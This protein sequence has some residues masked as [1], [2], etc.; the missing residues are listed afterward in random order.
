[1]P[2][3]YINPYKSSYLA[4]VQELQQ[5]RAELT[6]VA[7]RISQ[8]EETIAALEPLASG[9]GAAPTAG[10]SELCRQILMSQPGAAFTAETMMQHLAATGVDMSGY[11]NPLAV[12]HTT[13]TR[14]VKPGTG[15][16]K[17]GQPGTQPFYLYDENGVSAWHRRR[18]RLAFGQQ[19]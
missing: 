15:F 19:T 12:L 6:F 9:S 1:M 16:F 11:A 18:L 13:L 5:R 3:D 14:L 10:L 17:G 4:A 7:Q 2:Y 8:L